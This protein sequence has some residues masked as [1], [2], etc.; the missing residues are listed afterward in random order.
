[1]FPGRHVFRCPVRL[2]RTTAALLQS[3]YET[4]GVPRGATGKQIK[5]AYFDLAKKCHPDVST[6]ASSKDTFQRIS[7]SYQVLSD[8]DLRAE[9]NASIDEEEVVFKSDVYREEAAES[10]FRTA[11]GVNFEEL[12][13][14][15][16]GY[17]LE[18]DNAREYIL[19]LSLM[20]A[21]LGSA[22]YIEINTHQ[23]CMK[24]QGY[25][26]PE[27]VAATRAKCSR[28]YG[29]GEVPVEKP[30][31]DFSWLPQDKCVPDFAMCGDCGGKGYRIS[32]PC[33]SC[34]GKG[35]VDILEWHP[36]SVPPGVK[37]GQVL[38]CPG[39]DGAPMLIRV[40]ILSHHDFPF[41]YDEHDNIASTIH[42][43]YTTLVRGG[44]VFVNTI[45]NQYHRL[46]V[47]PLT[48]PGTCIELED[49]TPTHMYQ[50]S[51]MMPDNTGLTSH[52]ERTYNEMYVHEEQLFATTAQSNN[53]NFCKTIQ[54][55]T[56]SKFR[57]FRN[58]LYHYTVA[59]IYRLFIYWPISFLFDWA[60]RT[61]RF[62][63]L[64]HGLEDVRG[65]TFHYPRNRKDAL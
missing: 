6:D 43:Q 41:K 9:Y 25:G 36:V 53:V 34:S 24:C 32:R 42:V 4:L 51:L 11:F 16:F 7:K 63:R 38:N 39:I 27:G 61:K 35:R 19:G 2:L 56:L 30:A 54:V 33:P 22:K 26:T 46:F 13:D 52:L 48:Q 45:D 64:V 40:H 21:V 60:K 59:P 58:D 17:T 29:G 31:G 55:N 23:R 12:F 15:R 62:S 18:E 44:H 8:D 65:H 14:K 49:H 20:E 5:A 10:V 37:H 50:V 3:H 28:C 47:P 1:M 57:F